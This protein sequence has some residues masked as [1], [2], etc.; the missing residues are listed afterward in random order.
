MGKVRVETD[1]LA[2]VFR[3]WLN[4]INQRRPD[5]LRHLI[6]HKGETH[7]PERV[8]FAKAELARELSERIAGNGW[9]V[10]REESAQDTMWQD[11]E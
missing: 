9:E 11:T 4:V 6:T 5:I 2:K 8:R 10:M 3:I 7:D 1:E